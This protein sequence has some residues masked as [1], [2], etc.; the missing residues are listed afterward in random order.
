MKEILEGFLGT[1][2]ILAFGVCLGSL[3]LC[4]YLAIGVS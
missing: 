4:A 3:I 1:I 2:L